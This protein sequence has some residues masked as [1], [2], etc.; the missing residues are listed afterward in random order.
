MS[1]VV[2]FKDLS[3]AVEL[4]PNGTYSAKLTGCGSSRTHTAPG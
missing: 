4:V 1:I 3:G 2:K